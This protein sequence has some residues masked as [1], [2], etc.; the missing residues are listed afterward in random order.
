MEKILVIF[1][2]IVLSIICCKPETRKHKIQ[3]VIKNAGKKK[4]IL[5]INSR[6]CPIFT[7]FS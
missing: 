2:D 7:D 5:N 4:K 6:L 1:Q 3:C